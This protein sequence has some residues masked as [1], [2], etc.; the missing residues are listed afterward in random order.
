MTDPSQPPVPQYASW[1]RGALVTNL[2]GLGQ[3]TLVYI[4]QW[5][6]LQLTTIA[7]VGGR[8][9]TLAELFQHSPA[10]SSQ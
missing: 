6:Q 4:P 8:V 5:D 3:A 10:T 2:P 1:S 9:V 7:P